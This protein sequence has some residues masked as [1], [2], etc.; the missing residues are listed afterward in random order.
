MY[1]PSSKN[2]SAVLKTLP[3]LYALRIFS[4]TAITG[5]FS[6]RRN[7][8]TVFRFSS[9]MLNFCI[10]IF[11]AYSK[12]IMQFLFLLCVKDMPLLLL[13]M[14]G[15]LSQNLQIKDADFLPY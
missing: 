14:C 3:T 11:L 10:Q 6:D 1:M 9:S 13:Q 12:Y 7:S 2:A 8:S 4:S 5:V 15:T